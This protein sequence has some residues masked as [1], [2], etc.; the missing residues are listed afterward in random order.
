[1]ACVISEFAK[2]LEE[3]KAHCDRQ[4][5]ICAEKAACNL[6]IRKQLE[7]DERAQKKIDLFK[8][9]IDILERQVDCLA[10]QAKSILGMLDARTKMCRKLSDDL[11]EERAA[12]RPRASSEEA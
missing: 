12:K 2:H 1:M 10:D 11:A 8:K 7:E 9:K 3:G 5:T 4:T 6:E